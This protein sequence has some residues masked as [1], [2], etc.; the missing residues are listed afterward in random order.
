MAE[1]DEEREGRDC[2][3][4]D[5]A[6]DIS[7][8]GIE[9]RPCERPKWFVLRLVIDDARF[10]LFSKGAGTGIGSSLTTIISPRVS[11]VSGQ[12]G[13]PGSKEAM[14]WSKSAAT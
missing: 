4:V 2:K 11:A 7:A 8:R 14:A 1:Y 9:D 5:C 12:V 6:R 3:V 10:V 13:K